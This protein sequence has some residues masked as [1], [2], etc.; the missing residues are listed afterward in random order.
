[1]LI[2]NSALAWPEIDVSRQCPSAI[3]C[4]GHKKK[5]RV[6]RL[7]NSPFWTSPL[8][9]HDYGTI[10][11]SRVTNYRDIF[12]RR[13]FFCCTRS[14]CFNWGFLLS[15]NDLKRTIGFEIKT[16]QNMSLKFFTFRYTSWFWKI[17]FSTGNAEI[18]RGAFSTL[19][20]YLITIFSK[21]KAYSVKGC[22]SPLRENWI[23]V[24]SK[25][26]AYSIKGCFSPLRENW[27]PVSSKGKAYSVK[28]AFSTLRDYGDYFFNW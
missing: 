15:A 12:S 25:G 17:L 1:M 13:G 23:P 19:R 8:W 6:T 24:S 9:P 3:F 27:I 5:C 18:V 14:Q 7:L 26:K 22:F 20:D 21:G 16:L 4:A 10:F 28:G 2:S 11:L